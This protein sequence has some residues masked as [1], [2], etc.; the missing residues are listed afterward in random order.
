VR[1]QTIQPAGRRRGALRTVVVAVLAAAAVLAA[2]CGEKSEN[3]TPGAPQAF[4]LELD[5]IVNADHAG[6]FEAIDGGY[7]EQAGLDVKTQVPSDPSSPIRQ[8]AAGQV[9]LAISYEPE[10]VLARDQGLPV[11]AVAALVPQ[12]LTSLIWLPGSGIKSVADLR[13]KTV[14]TAGIPYQQAYL[15]AILQRENLSE[16]DL[17]VVDV[18]QGLLP[19]LLSGRADAILGGFLNIEGVDLSERGKNP[20]VTPVDRLG[21]PPYDE[22]VLVANSDT[23]GDDSDAIRRFLGALERGTEAAVRDPQAATDA[24][25]KAS[26]G[27]DPKLTRAQVDRTLPLLAPAGKQPYGYMDPQRWQNFAQFFA[28]DRLIHELPATDDLLTNDLL[29][30]NI[31]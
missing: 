25:L 7:F 22:L 12:P 1:T 29:P 10:V 8:V 21:I 3:T 4:T 2:G 24:V 31:P 9:D 5:W 28:N 13:G 20:V 27:L 30:G 6:I 19:A 11:K 16:D 14:A 17:N 18:Q 15:Q 26:R 23:L